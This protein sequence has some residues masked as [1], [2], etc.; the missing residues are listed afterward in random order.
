MR[1]RVARH[2][3]PVDCGGCGKSLPSGRHFCIRASRYDSKYLCGRCGMNEERRH[4]R[5]KD[6]V[7]A[8]AE[9]LDLSV[10]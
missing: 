10:E 1:V 7:L 4:S 6:D 2:D 3:R 8:V 5:P 9:D